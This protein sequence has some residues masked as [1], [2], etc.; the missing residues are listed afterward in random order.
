MNN[1]W[2]YGLLLMIVT[3][4]AACG[5]GG[6][7]G[8]DGD[9]AVNAP[10]GIYE[11]TVTAAGGTP[12]SAFGLITSNGKLAFLDLDTLEAIIG[13]ISNGSIS[14]TLFADSVAGITGQVTS[15]S[16]NNIGGT[17]S[18]SLGN[19]TFSLVADPNLYL[20]GASLSKLTGTWV[21]SVFTDGVGTT[22]WVFQTDGSYNMSS[23]SGC[24]GTG[25]FS[26]IDATKNEYEMNFVLSN[27]VPFNGTY[28]GIGALSD[29][30]NT[31]DSLAFMFSSGS[32]GGLFEPIKQ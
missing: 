11:G 28:T 2:N 8:D 22:T 6:G 23:T 7:G 1:L 31:D 25:Q 3:T 13:T 18:S 14:G 19:G 17:Y 24:T 15:A 29:T 4:L 16:G 5:G 26:L 21:D 10:P 32:V 20:R 27:C 30:Y 12:D 9:V